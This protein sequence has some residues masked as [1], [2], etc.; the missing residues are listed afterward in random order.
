MIFNKLERFNISLT[1]MQIPF[2]KYQRTG[3]DFIIIDNCKCLF[4]PPDTLLI[5][6]L[7]NPGPA[8]GAGGTFA[9]TIEKGA[10]DESM[11]GVIPVT[12]S[13]F[14][15]YLSGHFD[16]NSIIVSTSGGDFSVE[17]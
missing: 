4:N 17:S 9:L 10:E 11:S 13:A 2:N 3:K 16:R 14:A 6:K 15:S 1:Q 8:I 5:N 12:V 7:C